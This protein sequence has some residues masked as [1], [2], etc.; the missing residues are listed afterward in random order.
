MNE[1][2]NK[3]FDDPNWQGADQLAIYKAQPMSKV[4]LTTTLQ[5]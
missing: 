2:L 5:V 3:L 1:W 4:D